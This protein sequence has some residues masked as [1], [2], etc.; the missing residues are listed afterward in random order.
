MTSKKEEEWE[1]EVETNPEIIR[2]PEKKPE[3]VPVKRE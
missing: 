2:I 1:I 3:E